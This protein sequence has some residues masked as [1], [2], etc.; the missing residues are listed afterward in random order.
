MV[1]VPSCSH[2]VHVVL[3]TG[4]CMLCVGDCIC[5][6]SFPVIKDIVKH[7]F[8]LSVPAVCDS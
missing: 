5:E 6:Y 2:T 1:G 8:L 4:A 7:L 3:V